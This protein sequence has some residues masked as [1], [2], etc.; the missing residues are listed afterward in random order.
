[1]ACSALR[2]AQIH[3]PIIATVGR[4]FCTAKLI[5][6]I[7]RLMVIMVV[8]FGTKCHAF[9]MMGDYR[10]LGSWVILPRYTKSVGVIG[11]AKSRVL[12]THPSTS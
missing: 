1:M 12:N 9:F 3:R 5:R 2:N 4:S 7:V 10:A 11:E 8:F 6:K